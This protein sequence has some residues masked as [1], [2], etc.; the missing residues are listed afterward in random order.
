[1][2]TQHRYAVGETV[3]YFASPTNPY[4]SSGDYRIVRLLPMDGPYLQ[5]KVRSALENFDRVA[6]EWQLTT[7]SRYPGFRNQH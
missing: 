6:F 7:D 1:M 4:R 2:T 5:Y 3:H